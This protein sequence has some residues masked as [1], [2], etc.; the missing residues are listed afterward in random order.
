MSTPFTMSSN[1]VRYLRMC[2]SAF[3]PLLPCQF[4][5]FIHENSLQETRKKAFAL[6]PK[7]VEFKFCVKLLSINS[8]AY[9]SVLFKKCVG[10]KQNTY[11][12][13]M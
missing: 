9:Y 3:S 8:S 7:L 5:L 2:K 13:R 10:K 1:A 4:L 6:S 11:T 12:K